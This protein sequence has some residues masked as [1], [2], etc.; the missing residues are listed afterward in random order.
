[1]V[2]KLHRLALRLY[3]RLPT[4]GRRWVVRGLS[5][6]FT[7]GAMCL[8]ERS[9]GALLLVRHVYRQRWGVPGGLL[10]RGEEPA[11]AARREVREEVS[12]E[13]EL[14]GEPA[15]VVD[16]IPQRVDV[17]YRARPRLGADLSRIEPASPEIIE[18]RWFA[19]D[20]LPEL[21][22]ETAS[23][24]IAIARSSRS[25]QAPPVAAFGVAGFPRPVESREEADR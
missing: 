1:M 22:H 15:V 6:S 24:L 14:S 13:V 19:A 4:K 3:R 18:A 17:V 8:I 7:V 21:Q 2:A 10:K 5:P 16:A 23:A 25:P 11:D 20:R 9:D 12:L